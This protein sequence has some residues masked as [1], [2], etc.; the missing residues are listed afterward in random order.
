M[1]KLQVPQ[2]M[3]RLAVEGLESRSM[4]ATVFNAGG[5]LFIQGTGAVDDVTVTQTANGQFAVTQIIG[6]VESTTNYP[7]A[8]GVYADL[9]GGDDFLQLGEP[10]RPL[11]LLTSVTLR[12]GDGSDTAD[13]HVNIPGQVFIDGG[14]Q[15]GGAA[16]ND[17][18]FIDRSIIGS[19]LVNTYG[20]DDELYVYRSGVLNLIGNL[21]GEGVLAGPTDNDYVDFV[22]SAIGSAMLMLGGS[23]GEFGNEVL[24]S[25]TIFGMLTINGGNGVDAIAIDSEGEGFGFWVPSHIVNTA[26][27]LEPLL[28]SFLARLPIG[29]LL[30]NLDGLLERLPELG[31]I[32]LPGGIDLGDVLGMIGSID[33]DEFD[34]SDTL[35]D[36]LEDVDLSFVGDITVMGLLNI[37]TG[38]GADLVD[39]Q[40]SGVLASA[41]IN[42]GDGADEVNLFGFNVPGTLTVMLGSGA[43][44]LRLIGVSSSIAFLDGGA[45]SDGLLNVESTGLGRRL[46]SILSFE[47]AL[48]NPLEAL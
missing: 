42:T 41:T 9:G 5:L 3:R 16:Q 22:D 43:D 10:E 11:P 2:R 27:T 17:F 24:A 6:G 40:S 14:I 7:A 15:F 47:R 39:I 13:I 34:L 20:G 1:R 23:A 44:D 31:G 28:D 48:P 35:E 26:E 46:R 32:S 8:F 33:L 25:S 19:L 29:S 21:G 4:L 30:G 38:G 18:I 45:G 12:L 37:N 36:L